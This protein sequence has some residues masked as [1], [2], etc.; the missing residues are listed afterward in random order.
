M[1]NITQEKLQNDSIVLGLRKK[2]LR[3]LISQN[4][5]KSNQ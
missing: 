4:K 1:R 2:F 3:G 5:H